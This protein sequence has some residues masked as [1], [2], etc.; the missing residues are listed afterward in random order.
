MRAA[1]GND[2]VDLGDPEV[3][4]S[5]LHPRFVERV[6]AEAERRRVERS[7]DRHRALWAHWAAKEAAF[8]LVQKLRPGTIFAHRSFEVAEGLGAVRHGSLRLG[9]A[10]DVG[11]DR[12]HALAFTGEAPPP[13]RVEAIRG[14]PGDEARRI[15]RGLLAACLGCEPAALELVRDP[16]PRRADGLGPPRALLRGAPVDADLSLSHHGRFAAAAVVGR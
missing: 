6:L 3:H 9:L 13:C 1:V 2:V 14:P 11:A 8:K 16:D 7:P 12:V 4:P 5:A 10:L 15:V